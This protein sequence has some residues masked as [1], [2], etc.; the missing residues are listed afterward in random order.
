MKTIIISVV[1]L[2]IGFG[3]GYLIL[4]PEEA[5]S[6]SVSSETKQLYTCGM[7]P[8]IISDEPG[9]CP[10]CGMKLIPKLDSGTESGSIVVDPTTR[11]NMGMA[12]VAV[13][14]RPISREV[15]AFGKVKYA[16]PNIY[17]INLKFEGWIEKLFVDYE[18]KKVKKGDPLLE[19]YS[20][21]LVAAQKEFLIAYKSGQK[22][23]ASNNELATL[24]ESSRK[25]LQNFD[26]AEDQIDK[27][28]STGEIIRT[29][30]LRSPASGIVAVKKVSDG[31]H[32][33]P[34][35]ELY[36]IVDISTVWVS[37]YIYEDELP[38]I[39][40]GQKADVIFPNL[41][42]VKR[43]ANLSYIS[44][45]LEP[46]RQVEIR[47]NI[48]NV[49]FLLKPDMYA[50]VTI[51]SALKLDRLAIPRSAVINSGTRQIVFIAKGEDSFAPRQI[52]TGAIGEDDYIEVQSGLNRNEK[53]VVSGQF[54]LDSESRLEEALDGEHQHGDMEPAVSNDT[55]NHQAEQ[56][57]SNKSIAEQIYTCPMPEHFHVL[58]YG[59]GACPECGMKLVPVEET[60]N[61][62]VYYC[63]MIKDQVVSDRP[64]NCP[65]CNMSLVKLERENNHD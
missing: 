19:V 36:Q 44:P 7:H 55:D 47:F 10:I 18:G 27:L 3:A 32:L 48:D 64:G 45:Y 53:V 28:I 54:L 46:G 2:L 39:K 23:N 8:Q 6:S 58:Q 65:K 60:D 21:N 42:D 31:E 26:I 57:S 12:T 16:E 24:L 62:E 13:D 40:L 20:P 59:P 22:T 9:Y 35:T 25:R 51:K 52:I 14:Y 29:V 5:D 1:M 4:A 49:D 15:R 41:I 50:E 38:F 30:T 61:T 63:P 43:E 33:M 56:E 11:Q 17:T 34:G 37:A